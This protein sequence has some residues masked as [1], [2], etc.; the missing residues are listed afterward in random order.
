MRDKNNRMRIFEVSFG[1]GLAPAALAAKPSRACALS[2][3]TYSV[4][5]QADEISGAE[6]TR[7]PPGALLDVAE[8]PER[9]L[10][11]RVEPDGHGRA[12]AAGARG[13]G[14]P[15]RAGGSGMVGERVRQGRGRAALWAQLAWVGGQVV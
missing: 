11:G 5:A 9:L 6:P 4:V 8:R 13:E 12:L 7:T 2:G 3:A 14:G 1:R 15:Q 10:L